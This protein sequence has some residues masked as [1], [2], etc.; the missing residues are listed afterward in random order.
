MPSGKEAAT[1]NRDHRS[2]FVYKLC[3]LLLSF[4]CESLN[5]RETQPFVVTQPQMTPLHSATAALVILIVAAASAQSASS[6]ST[7][8]TPTN[9]IKPS[10]A[11]GYQ[12]ALV[13]TGLTKP[14]SIQFDSA[15]NLLV[16]Q[17]GSGVESLQL[18][19][20]GGT[21]VSVKSKKSLVSSKGVSGWKHGVLPLVAWL[22][23][24]KSGHRL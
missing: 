3:K 20:N 14:R 9:S 10:L 12:A 6:C 4:S 19:D 16:V 13:A 1:C 21:C 18:Q 24:L 17:A 7:T 22:Y 15:G 5:I 8:L 2:Y 23:V 11:S